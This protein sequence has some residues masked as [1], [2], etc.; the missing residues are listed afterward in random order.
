MYS[1]TSFTARIYTFLFQKQR[2]TEW[3]HYQTYLA[4]MTA[5][6]KSSSNWN[7]CWVFPHKRMSV[8]VSSKQSWWKGWYGK[9]SYSMETLVTLGKSDGTSWLTDR[10]TVIVISHWWC[11]VSDINWNFSKFNTKF[12]TV[13]DVEPLSDGCQIH[14]EQVQLLG[15]LK[16]L[17][18]K[19]NFITPSASATRGSTVPQ[20]VC[21]VI[22]KKRQLW[23]AFWNQ[24]HQTTQQ[25]VQKIGL[26]ADRILQAYQYERPSGGLKHHHKPHPMW[27]DSH[28]EINV[29]WK[30]PIKKLSK[31]LPTPLK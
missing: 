9:D 27:N 1:C 22:R 15:K 14:S 5:T 7:I 21:V 24:I 17:Q 4:S 11:V 16:Q 30:E 10:A 28:G 13:W 6:I 31:G 25:N 2:F 20:T 26:N 23:H 18:V 12:S 19:E 29:N 3:P 8:T